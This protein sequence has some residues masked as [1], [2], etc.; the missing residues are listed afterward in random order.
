MTILYI[1]LPKRF[2]P[3]TNVACN[4][5]ETIVNDSW[6]NVLKGNNKMNETQT[7]IL[8]GERNVILFGVPASKAVTTE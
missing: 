1:F 8:N 5:H 6:A 4:G 2:R 3:L 7:N